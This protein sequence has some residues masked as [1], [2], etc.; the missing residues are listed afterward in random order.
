MSNNHRPSYARASLA[1]IM[2]DP[3]GAGNGSYLNERAKSEQ[4]GNRC[5]R[6]VRAIGNEVLTA[7]KSFQR[8]A[9]GWIERATPASFRLQP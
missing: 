3:F 2:I 8:Q 7:A 9:I 6:I 5:E 1:V 4:K